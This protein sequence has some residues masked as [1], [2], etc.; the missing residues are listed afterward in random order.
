LLFPYN[1]IS[2]QPCA[3]QIT[4]HIYHDGDYINQFVSLRS[5]LA[6]V[7]YFAEVFF[8]RFQQLLCH[9]FSFEIVKFYPILDAMALGQ[10]FWYFMLGAIMV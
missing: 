1:S 4:A 2:T 5:I 6:W 8:Y 10:G 7:D 3:P 9:G